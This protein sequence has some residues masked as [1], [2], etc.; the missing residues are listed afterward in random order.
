MIYCIPKPLPFRQTPQTFISYRQ[1]NIF[2]PFNI[3]EPSWYLLHHWIIVGWE[4]TTETVGRRK[5]CVKYLN[6]KSNV[7]QWRDVQHSSSINHQTISAWASMSLHI[8]PPRVFFQ[9]LRNGSQQVWWHESLNELLL[10]NFILSVII[11]NHCDLPNEMFKRVHWEGKKQNQNKQKK[12]HWAIFKK[13]H[14]ASLDK[15]VEGARHQHG[16]WIICCVWTLLKKMVSNTSFYLP[17]NLSVQE[18]QIQTTG[19]ADKTFCVLVARNKK[20]LSCQQMFW[21]GI[22]SHRKDYLGILIIQQ[23]RDCPIKYSAIYWTNVNGA[24]LGLCQRSRQ[25]KSLRHYWRL[26]WSAESESVLN[27]NEIEEKEK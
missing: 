22:T 8:W 10:G 12:P 26:T 25:A 7:L 4:R 19:F 20:L 24:N 1:I 27:R 9:E 17:G 14:L 23:N 18:E 16:N 3:V 2:P 6:I 21:L 11:S 13:L 15:S 5:L